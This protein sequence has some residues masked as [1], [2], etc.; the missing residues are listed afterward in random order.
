MM[1][2]SMAPMNSAAQAPM[3]TASR[4]SIP[5]VHSTKIPSSLTEAEYLAMQMQASKFTRRYERT[6][7]RSFGKRNVHGLCVDT[8]FVEAFMDF[9]STDGR[10][11][12]VRKGDIIRVWCNGEVHSRWWLGTVI[13]SFYGNKGNGYFFPVLVEEY[14]FMD[15]RIAS[16]IPVACMEMKRK[17]RSQSNNAKKI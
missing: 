10:I 17:A 16:R 4:L 15:N 5:Q 8:K 1:M 14:N 2:Q 11:L 9:E 13:K 7:K 6:I 3:A 12:S